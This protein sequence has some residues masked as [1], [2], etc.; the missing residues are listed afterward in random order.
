MIARI[1]RGEVPPQK[2]EA[3]HQYLRDTGLKDYS[4]TPGNLGVCLLMKKHENTTEFQTLTFWKDY[5]S[6][7]A[8]AGEDFERARYYPAD[9][10]F[11]IQMDEFVTHFEV[12]EYP[13]GFLPV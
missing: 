12:L 6:I 11:L 7:K 8:F 1:W 2:A 5:D 3:Y 4:S 13:R 10:D 9:L